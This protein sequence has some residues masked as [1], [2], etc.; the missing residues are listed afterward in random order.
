MHL[1]GWS[2]GETELEALA[3]GGQQVDPPILPIRRAL[4]MG[5]RGARHLWPSSNH[6]LTVSLGFVT[7]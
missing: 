5:V 2:M 7:V 1:R 6:F 3:F 4:L